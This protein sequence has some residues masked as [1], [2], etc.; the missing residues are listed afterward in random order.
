MSFGPLAGR[1]SGLL[2]PWSTK[3]GPIAQTAVFGATSRAKVRHGAKS[4]RLVP[5]RK[6]LFIR[7]STNSG[8]ERGKLAPG[9]Q[10]QQTDARGPNF[11]C[12]SNVR[13]AFA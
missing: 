13:G 7:L 5:A 10:Q 6:S 4:A 3:G 9:S 11:G 2:A 8:R 1:L 12:G